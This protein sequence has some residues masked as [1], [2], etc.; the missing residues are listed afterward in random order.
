MDS[1]YLNI[2]N[3]LSRSKTTRMLLFVGTAIVVNIVASF[4]FF[5]IDLTSDRRFSISP[6]SKEVLSGLSDYVNITVYLDGEM[7]IGFKKLKRSVKEMLDEFEVYGGSNFKFRFVN[8]SEATD[9]KERNEAYKAIFD[10][11]VTPIN[12][13]D[14]DVEGGSTEKIVFPGATVNY[15]G[16]QL[17]INFLTNVPGLSG[18]ENLNR[19]IQNVE[20]NLINTIEKLSL[21]TL[22]AIA[23]IEGHGEWAAPQVGDITK[24]L[25]AYYNVSRITLNG[26]AAALNGYK[27]AIVAGGKSPW[28]EVDKFVLDQF[29]MKGGR[30]AFFIDPVEVS[31]DSLAKGSMTVAMPNNTNLDD[32]FFTYGV[33]LNAV[34]L[35]DMQCSAIPI[36]VAL[37]GE[38][39][40]FVPAPWY[41]YPLLETSNEHPIT[42]NLN[43]VKTQFCS[44]VDTLSATPGITKK[45][46][47]ASSPYARVLTAP[48]MV[49]LGQI[50][51]SP[52]KYEFNQKHLPVAVLLEG[53][54]RS[55]FRNRMISEYIPNASVSLVNNSSNT[56]IAVIADADIIRNDIKVRPEGISIIP[57][58]YDKYT[59]QTYGNKDFVRNLISYLTDSRDLIS[60]R[61]RDLKLRLLDRNKILSGRVTWQI[62]NVVVPSAFVVLFGILFFYLRKRKYGTPQSK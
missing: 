33:R 2:K 29:I 9:A 15:R 24:E 40:N 30:V 41:Y 17:P 3:W 13:H 52:L 54:F 51:D 1:I 34:L 56:K 26:N 5:R 25:T 57:L 59:S 4:F 45:R 36:N 46:L 31:E 6:Q 58:G 42:R 23:F 55:V 61:N 19:S 37:A 28:P 38:R 14:K 50:R 44:V 60:L 35:Q 49:N 16:R 7:P 27:L 12:I 39:P 11:G 53:T 18:E 8:P 20:Y 43:L 10:R 62:I 21:D 48:L 32:L 47:L 22:T